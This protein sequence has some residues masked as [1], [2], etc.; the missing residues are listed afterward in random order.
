MLHWSVQGSLECVLVYDTGVFV[1]LNNQ[2]G[3]NKK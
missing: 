3:L 1:I 2:G